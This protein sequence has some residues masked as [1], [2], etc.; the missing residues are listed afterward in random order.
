MDEFESAQASWKTPLLGIALKKVKA[1]DEKYQVLFDKIS[2]LTDKEFDSS[3]SILN[4]DKIEQK[5][6]SSANSLIVLHIESIKYTKH[7]DLKVKSK[8]ELKRLDLPALFKWEVKHNLSTLFLNNY[9]E[10]DN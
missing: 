8:L 9:K 5:L 7:E 4:F 2:K 6:K 3:Y 1:K 10:F